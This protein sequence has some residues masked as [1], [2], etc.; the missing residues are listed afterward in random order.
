MNPALLMALMAFQKV[1]DEAAD[2]LDNIL[3]YV[4]IGL[5]VIMPLYIIYEE[6]KERQGLKQNEEDM[7]AS[8]AG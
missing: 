5:W 3:F 7:A 8:E 4:M 1:A 6:I 2:N